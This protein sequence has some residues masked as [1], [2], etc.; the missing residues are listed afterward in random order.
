[1]SDLGKYGRCVR[2]EQIADANEACEAYSTYVRQI[3]RGMCH[4]PKERVI[5]FL[6]LTIEE[7]FRCVDTDLRA[8]LLAA[9]DP[10]TWTNDMRAD[11]RKRIAVIMGRVGEVKHE[12]LCLEQWARLNKVHLNPLH[13][14]GHD[15]HE[16]LLW[17]LTP[18]EWARE[19]RGMPLITREE[20]EEWKDSLD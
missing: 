4:S 14:H 8:F 18:D 13:P 6:S 20:Y 7:T 1:M 19:Q 3:V 11:L 5:V 9:I 16:S 2:R 10:R 12:M 17:A 15:Y